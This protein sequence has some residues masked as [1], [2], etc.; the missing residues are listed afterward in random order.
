MK[1]RKRIRDY[2][3]PENGKDEEIRWSKNKPTRKDKENSE[4]DE[5][6]REIRQ[7]QNHQIPDD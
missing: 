1:I 6:E 3:K 5:G 4:I 7:P 2:L